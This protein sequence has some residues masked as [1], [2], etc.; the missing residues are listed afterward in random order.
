MFKSKKASLKYI[1]KILDMKI[2]IDYYRLMTFFEKNSIEIGNIKIVE[3][4]GVSEL[5]L[6]SLDGFGEDEVIDITLNSQSLMNFLP[7]IYHDKDFLKRYLFGIQSSILNINEIIFNISKEFRP[8]TSHYIDWLSSWFGIEYGDIIDEKAKRKIVANVVELYQSRGT[9]SY[10]IILIKALVDVDIIIDDDKNSPLN[11][12]LSTKRQ[13]AFSVIIEDKLS[14]DKDEE[15]RKYSI[16]QNI[17]DKEKPVNTKV[18]IKYNYNI[19]EDISDT[20]LVS[21]NDDIRDDS[22]DY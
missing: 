11:R 10:F 7:L 19:E 8:E 17:F 4:R 2:E 5:T 20:K 15:S 21:F 13:R 3:I 6:V 16:I 22:Y 9:K 14:E 12:N 18:F 1:Q